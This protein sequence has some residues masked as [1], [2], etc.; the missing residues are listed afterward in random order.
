VHVS[1]TLR[2]AIRSLDAMQ[3]HHETFHTNND[4]ARGK[5]EPRRWDKASSRSE[6]QLQFLQGLLERSEANNARIQ[7]EIT[8][9]SPVNNR[10]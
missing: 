1:E 9:V 4:L 2:V 10:M 3:H 7:N 6:F 8:L 5:I